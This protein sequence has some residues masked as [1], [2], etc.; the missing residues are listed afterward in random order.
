MSPI[1]N[2]ELMR[3]SHFLQWFDTADR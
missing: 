1:V 3:R 2:E